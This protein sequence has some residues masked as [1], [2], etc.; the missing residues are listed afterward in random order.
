VDGLD[1]K[2]QFLVPKSLDF[3]ATRMGAVIVVR[4][5]VFDLYVE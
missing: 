5:V 2:R 1:S 3:L 4:Y